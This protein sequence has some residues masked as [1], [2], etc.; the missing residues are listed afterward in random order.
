[1]YEDADDSDCLR[2]DA[3]AFKPLAGG[4]LIPAQ[5]YFRS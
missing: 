5:A 2:T 4:C 1:M 3:A